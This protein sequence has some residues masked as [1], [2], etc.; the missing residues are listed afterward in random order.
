MIDFA[1]FDEPDDASRYLDKQSIGLEDR[2]GDLKLQNE[3]YNC[4]TLKSWYYVVSFWNDKNE[5]R[6]NNIFCTK[7]TNYLCKDCNIY[8][9]KID[10]L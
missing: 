10:N 2:P 4:W 5:L 8:N 3:D 7:N 1:R 6:K 9:T